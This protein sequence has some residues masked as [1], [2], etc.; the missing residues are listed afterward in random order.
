MEEIKTAINHVVR[1]PEYIPL[2]LNGGWT[3]NNGS[4]IPWFSLKPAYLDKVDASVRIETYFAERVRNETPAI[5]IEPL[6]AN[7]LDDMNQRV[8]P[9]V[10]RN[11]YNAFILG[12]V[13]ALKDFWGI[14]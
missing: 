7:I 14:V 3:N 11:Y 10:R 9:E 1:L 8:M 13:Q 5:E 2:F 6:M 12:D 4:F